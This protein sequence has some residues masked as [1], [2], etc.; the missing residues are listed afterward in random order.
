[1]IP[2]GER[3][4]FNGHISII[5]TLVMDASDIEGLDQF[6]RESFGFVETK[7]VHEFRINHKITYE[8]SQKKIA[9]NN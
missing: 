8:N 6:L 4:L 7:F 9:N 3:A 2:I 5:A 1:M